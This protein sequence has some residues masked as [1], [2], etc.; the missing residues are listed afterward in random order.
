MIAFFTALTAF[1]LSLPPELRALLFFAYWMI[2]AWLFTMAIF[3]DYSTAQESD[4]D[5]HE[6]WQTHTW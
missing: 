6:Y 2:D 3:G 4:D 1:I 5:E